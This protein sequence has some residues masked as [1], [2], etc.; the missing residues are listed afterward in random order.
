[1]SHRLKETN[2]VTSDDQKWQRNRIS[3]D[4][5]NLLFRENL[6]VNFLWKGNWKGGIGRIGR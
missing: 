2:S 1:M 4:V 3:S 5:T 6:W